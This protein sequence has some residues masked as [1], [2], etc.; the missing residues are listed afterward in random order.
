MMLALLLAA[1]PC[2]EVTDRVPGW[3]QVPL[4]AEAP[5]LAAPP[6][7]SQFR[8]GE[9]FTIIDEQVGLYRT[10]SANGGSTD[11]ELPLGTGAQS[12]TLVFREPLRGAKVDVT[13]WD[14]TLVH[15][16]RIAGTQ[17]SFEWGTRDVSRVWV[18]VH[19]H[20][21]EPPVLMEVRVVRS[22]LPQQLGLP[23]PFNA[24]DSL[25][26]FQPDAAPV[27]LCEAGAQPLT[28]RAEK[29]LLAK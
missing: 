29:L 20:L 25:F 16:K 24:V 4:P 14:M 1:A 6:S 18:R 27:R 22:V 13:S 15:E 26:Y 3:K 19:Q 12:V 21:R 7:F 17:L 5:H 11:F 28:V 8:S 10:G 23:A 2:I 9:R